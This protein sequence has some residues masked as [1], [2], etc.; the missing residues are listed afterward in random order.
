MVHL[1][2]LRKARRDREVSQAMLA[3]RA[4][5]ART[6]I[7]E[8]ERGLAVRRPEHVAQLAAVLGVQESELLRRPRRRRAGMSEALGMLAGTRAATPDSSSP[9]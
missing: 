1:W 2:G 7:V 4:D 6:Y 9:F 5:V 3:A 8:L